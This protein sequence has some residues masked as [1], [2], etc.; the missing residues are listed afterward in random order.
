VDLSISASSSATVANRTYGT[1]RNAGT[2]DTAK[3]KEL[4]D[5]L[6]A[7]FPG[8][9]VAFDQLPDD[10]KEQERLARAGKLAGLTIHPV[11]ADRMQSDGAFR[12]QVMSGIK[13]DREANPVGKI[14]NVG[15]V[16]IET[17]GHGTVVEKDGSINSWTLSKSTTSTGDSDEKTSTTKTCKKKSLLE[18]LQEQIDKKKQQ[19]KISKERY[20]KIKQEADAMR[21]SGKSDADIA[22]KLREAYLASMSPGESPSVGV[23]TTA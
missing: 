16:K 23:E 5:S 12:D 18:A 14:T 9:S 2:D 7:A 17:V 6:N 11:A 1:E 20:E 8:V 13:A 3:R 10:Q 15:G 19:D 4:L 22:A 21:A